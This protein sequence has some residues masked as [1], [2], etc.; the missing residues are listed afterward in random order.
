MRIKI[1]G[2][3][4]FVGQSL[5]SFFE[6]EGNEVESLSVRDSTSVE[7]VS[8]AIDGCDVLINLAGVSI[9]GR[10]SEGYKRSLYESRIETTKKLLEALKNTQNRPKHF[11]STSAIGIYP[12]EVAC[13]ETRKEF[14]SSF[15]A[16]TCLDWEK[17]A[18]KAQDLGIKTSIFRFGVVLGKSGGMIKKIWLPF[19]L[20]L[21]GR[22]GNGEQSLSWIHIE[23][24]CAA[25]TEVIKK[26]G[27]GIYNLCSPE[28][29]NNLI[30]TK[31]LG[32]L[33]RR[34]TI[35]PVPAFVLRLIFGEGS[36]FMLQ[37]QKVYP[38]RLLE[39]GFEFKYKNIEEALKS[40]L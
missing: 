27:E 11:I 10:W 15:L 35:F 22:V 13:D 8:D 3:S 26:E 12:N 5:K 9:F 34:P 21:G 1:V 17:E 29:T 20:G 37:G 31:T 6:K 14:A 18:L 32:S 36:D 25:Y 19:S 40:F 23:D 28:P 38:K 33:M 16:N 24:L 2:C 7:K 39:A 30:L 4:G